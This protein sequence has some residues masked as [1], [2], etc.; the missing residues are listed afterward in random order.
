[1][2]LRDY[3][4]V[5]RTNR[6]IARDGAAPYISYQIAVGVFHLKQFYRTKVRPSPIGRLV[7]NG[8]GLSAMLPEANVQA[9]GRL[10]GDTC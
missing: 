8:R 6:H 3:M 2:S 10:V 4:T 9:S 1:M 5:I 7:L